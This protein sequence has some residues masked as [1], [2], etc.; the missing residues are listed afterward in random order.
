MC[1]RSRTSCWGFERT[2]TSFYSVLHICMYV[3][4][5][6]LLTQAGSGRLQAEL[7]FSEPAKQR[8]EDS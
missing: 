3:S 4:V 5:C 6:V 1:E 2:S 8:K 7:H